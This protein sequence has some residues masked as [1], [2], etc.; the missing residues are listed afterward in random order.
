MYLDGGLIMAD[1]FYVGFVVVFFASCWG[2][3]VLLE[4][5]EPMR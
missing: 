1:L 4:N 5:I 3:F 2:M